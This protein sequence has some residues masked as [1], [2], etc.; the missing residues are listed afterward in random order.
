MKL[1]KKDVCFLRRID[2]T[3]YFAL[4]ESKGRVLAGE[5]IKTGENHLYEISVERKPSVDLHLLR[6][7][8]HLRVTDLMTDKTADTVLG[9]GVDYEPDDIEEL[10]KEENVT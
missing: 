9:P 10:F 2:N 8:V 1:N 7:I 4:D 6:C 5:D 3:S